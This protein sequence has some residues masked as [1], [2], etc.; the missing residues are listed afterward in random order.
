MSIK[1][2]NH[3]HPS[4]VGLTFMAKWTIPEEGDCNEDAV[5]IWMNKYIKSDKKVVRIQG[6][7]ECMISLFTGAHLLI[8]TLILFLITLPQRLPRNFD[9]FEG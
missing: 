1:L 5:C 9:R 8:Q 4:H 3:Y 7:P 6:K 2:K